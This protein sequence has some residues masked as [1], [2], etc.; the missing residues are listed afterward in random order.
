MKRT[1][2]LSV[3]LCFVLLWGMGQNSG[4]YT[5]KRTNV[6]T[7]TTHHYL[8]KF[9]KGWYLRPEVGIS[10]PL[11]FEFFCGAGYQ[12]NPYLYVGLGAG[13]G[14][15]HFLGYTLFGHTYKQNRLS[16]IWYSTTFPL[17]ATFKLHFLTTK[18]G[19]TPFFETK[20]GYAFGS[21][22]DE[23][24]IIEPSYYYNS[25][26]VEYIV[27]GYQKPNGFYGHWGI[28]GSYKDFNLLLS[29]RINQ[30]D[31]FYYHL[32]YSST[33]RY[34]DFSHSFSISL[35]YNIPLKKNNR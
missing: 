28:G 33:E 4:T 18:K 10:L 23:I 6:K 21:W 34:F 35:A 14:S 22:G 9:E 11:Q 7:V 32:F 12:I 29:Y 30:V 24:F 13:V 31:C 20:M 1:F 3:V 25:E 8:P 16:Q 2:I 19:F 17:F 5:A 15:F 27:K 26:Y